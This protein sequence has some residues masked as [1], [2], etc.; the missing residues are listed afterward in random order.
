[1]SIRTRLMALMAGFAATALAIAALGLMTLSDYQT[2]MVD[3]NRAWENTWRGERLNH[4][5]SNVVMESR[6]LYSAATP[7]EVPIFAGHLLRDLDDI[8]ALLREWKASG[9]AEAKWV[10]AIEPDVAR[11]SALRRQMVQL[12]LAGRTADT[13]AL[14]LSNRADRTAFQD[15]LDAMVA[16]I[17]ANLD[18]ARLRAA[19][20]SRWRAVDFAAAAGVGVLLMSAIALWALAQFVTRPLRAVARAIIDTA[21]SDYSIP[22]PDPRGGDEISTVWRALNVLKDRAIEAERLAALQRE[23]EHQ[24]E[25]ELRQLILD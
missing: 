14:G 1:M 24:K 17:R 11:F 2:M 10:A 13:H 12:A 15:H 6:G 3:N 5:V 9:P 22:L 25:I 20:Y 19:Q 21:E 7:A 18:A 8:Q 16:Q 4:L 23:A